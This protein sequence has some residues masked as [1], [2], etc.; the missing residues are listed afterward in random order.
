MGFKLKGH[1]LAGFQIWFA[2]IIL[3][4]YSE[5][6]SKILRSVILHQFGGHCLTKFEPHHSCCW[7]QCW[8][9]LCKRWEAC[10]EIRSDLMQRL[11]KVTTNLQ[12]FGLSGRWPGGW[13]DYIFEFGS[14]ECYSNLW[15]WSWIDNLK[16]LRK[17]TKV[18]KFIQHYFSKHIIKTILE[19]PVNKLI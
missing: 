5:C 2:H 4:Q 9:N 18:F 1:L 11:Q 8:C 3:P 12:S 17:K 14:L 7:K 10:I 19:W 13:K 6:H 15:F 16:P